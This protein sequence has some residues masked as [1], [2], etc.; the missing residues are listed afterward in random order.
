MPMQCWAGSQRSVA[1]RL[2]RLPSICTGWKTT[3][4]A[5]NHRVYVSTGNSL[6]QAYTD[7]GR[8]IRDVRTKFLGN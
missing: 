2:M 7:P 4:A 1:A 8:T 3:K 5:R 6:L